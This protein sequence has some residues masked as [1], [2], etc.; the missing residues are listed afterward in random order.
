VS[1]DNKEQGISV[2]NVFYKFPL[3]LQDCE[4]IANEAEAA[5]FGTKDG[6][7]KHDR[8]VRDSLTIDESQFRLE[9]IPL[10]DFP[11]GVLKLRRFNIYG[12]GG[13]FKRHVDSNENG[14]AAI[15]VM[16]LPS[17]F[18]GGELIVDKNVFEFANSDKMHCVH[19]P[20]DAVHE[21]RPVHDGWKLTLT[22]DIILSSGNMFNDQTFYRR[23]WDTRNQRYYREG[24]LGEDPNICD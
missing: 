18:S 11:N 6:E 14:A 7:R 17:T 21:A 4:S 8:T 5:T 1:N 22:Y 15:L 3:S 24:V 20:V 9:N 12:P 2:K 16:C 23:E 13:F 10:P 19:F